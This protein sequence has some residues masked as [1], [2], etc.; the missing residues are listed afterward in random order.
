VFHDRS[1]HIE[2]RYHFI[3]DWVQRGA[4]QLQY[5]PTDEQVADIFTKAL[6]R[7]KYVVEI[8]VPWEVV[9]YVCESLN[10]KGETITLIP[11]L[12]VLISH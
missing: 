8:W 3:R 11:L 12:Y 5:I 1:K 7:G 6:P 9:L 2:I 4:V 10:T